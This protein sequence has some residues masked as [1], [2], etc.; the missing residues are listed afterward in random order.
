M[1][2]MPALASLRMPCHDLSV[3]LA[4]AAL[5]TGLGSLGGTL[6]QL[7]LR[8]CGLQYSF[9]ELLPA[10]RQLGRSLG[11]LRLDGNHLC[12]QWPGVVMEDAAAGAAHAALA[13]A[14][15]GL[16]RLTHLDLGN[17]GIGAPAAE[18]LAPAVARLACLQHLDL[19]GNELGD[20]CVELLA[21]ALRGLPALRRL[22]VCDSGV[23][24][25]GMRLLE[26]LQGVH[27]IEFAMD[28]HYKV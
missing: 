13:E 1:Q 18:A 21:P 19:R 24:A 15:S 28:A 17:N 7:D 10:F 25:H 8:R 16:T 26:A 4:C 3:D 23:S 2:C 22:V 9:R 6:Q 11:R 14:V 5:A 12:T 20:G 27:V